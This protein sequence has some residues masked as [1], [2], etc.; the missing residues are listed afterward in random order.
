MAHRFGS[1]IKIVCPRFGF[2]AIVRKSR[3]SARFRFGC[4]TL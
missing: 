4:L 2:R 1:A 3:L